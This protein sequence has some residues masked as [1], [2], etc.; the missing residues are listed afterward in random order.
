[1]TNGQQPIGGIP[2]GPGAQ[3]AAAQW[4]LD[5]LAEFGVALPAGNRLQRAKALLQDLNA[6]RIALAETDSAIVERINEAQWTI[7]EQYLVAR[8]LG[9]PPRELS[10]ARHLKLREML[11][12]AETAGTDRNSLARNTQFEQYVA[13][14]FAMADIPFAIAEPDLVFEYNGT[15]VG[16]AAKRVQSLRQAARRA[17]EAAEQIAAS[18]ML[19]V[20]ALNLDVLLLRHADGTGPEATLAERLQVVD[21]IES[22]MADRPQVIATMTFGRD[23]IWTFQGER[24]TVEISHTHRFTAHPKTLGDA[25]HAQDFFDRMTTRIQDRM[26]TL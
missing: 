3:I 21:T 22:R 1:M 10:E 11:S 2:T 6:G 17:D 4:T 9:L 16:L 12:G 14:L 5:R 13:A 23:S 18:G 19:G 15:A 24:P 8:S 20:V 25:A 7:I 26:H